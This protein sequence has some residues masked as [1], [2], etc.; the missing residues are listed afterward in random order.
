MLKLGKIPITPSIIKQ[1]HAIATLDDMPQGLKITNK[2]NNVIFDSACITG[3][4]YDEE[5]IQ[6]NKCE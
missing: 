3:V 4:D 5:K 6:D 2:E 1:V